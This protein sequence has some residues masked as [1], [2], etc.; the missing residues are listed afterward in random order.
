VASFIL[1]IE[2]LYCGLEIEIMDCDKLSFILEIE[3]MD[4]G[5]FYL[6]R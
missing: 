3:L 1:E 4:C 2:L 5:F 6:R